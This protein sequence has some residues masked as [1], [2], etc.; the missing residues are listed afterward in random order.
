MICGDMFLFNFCFFF[1]GFNLVII[2]VDLGKFFIVKKILFFL[3][4]WF[5]CIGFIRVVL[6]MF[7]FVNL[8]LVV[9]KLIR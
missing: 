7:L 6:R 4:L 5:C 3:K 8:V 1:V 2:G 9:F